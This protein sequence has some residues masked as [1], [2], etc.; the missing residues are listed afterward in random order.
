MSGNLV[1]LSALSSVPVAT[2]AAGFGLK[3][4]GVVQLLNDQ[5]GVESLYRY[6]VPGGFAIEVDRYK[7]VPD[8]ELK[9]AL[10]ALS[11]G[12]KHGGALL[13]R[14]SSVEEKPGQNETVFV[15]V[16][17]HDPL[18]TFG[19]FCKAIRRVCGSSKG[20]GALVMP[21]VSGPARCVDDDTALG[22]DNV[23][24][25]ADTHSASNVRE[26]YISFVNGLG[27]GAVDSDRNSIL[28]TVE[29]E[30]SRITSFVNRTDQAALFFAKGMWPVT[31]P[32]EYRQQ[33]IDYFS[34][35]TGNMEVT[36]FGDPALDLTDEKGNLRQPLLMIERGVLRLLNE[37]EDVRYYG[38]GLPD[39]IQLLGST[40]FVSPAPLMHLIGVL[41]FLA[42][43][44]DGPIQVEGAFSRSSMSKPSLYQRID[45]PHNPVS[46]MNVSGDG[47][48]GYSEN[49][50]GTCDVR[51][52]LIALE[53]SSV[54][55]AEAHCS[56]LR[57]VDKRFSKTGYA[58]LALKHTSQII[59]LTPHCT[60]RLSV[61]PENMA[62]HAATYARILQA[63]KPG[64]AAVLASQVKLSEPLQI[65]FNAMS[66]GQSLTPSWGSAHL[67]SPEALIRSNG[68]TLSV[69]LD[70]PEPSEPPAALQEGHSFRRWLRSLFTR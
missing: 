47:A 3:T 36:A 52:P 45:V 19:R 2:V 59:E 4:A 28:V 48:D 57:K 9:V 12:M 38:K 6:E 53:K 42:S 56:V 61:F 40:P 10:D 66:R 54:L 65:L 15:H 13:V 43:T 32:A 69:E 68:K 62:S 34:L 5:P 51:A 22:V 25:V 29:R 35:R 11:A 55:G 70:P 50:I 49:V 27:T 39:G 16:D 20:M 24:F 31:K 17:A 67:L 58:L 63:R 44:S 30:S 37:N 23:S 1:N 14:S 26:M 18:A 64:T 60:V 21:L 7:D 41:R 46:D 8:A 33:H